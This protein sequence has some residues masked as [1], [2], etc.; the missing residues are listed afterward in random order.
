MKDDPKSRLDATTWYVALLGPLEPRPL[1]QWLTRM[2]LFAVLV[3]LSPTTARAQVPAEEV[4]DPAGLFK[5][6]RLLYL[7]DQCEAAL[8]KLKKVVEQTASP[9]AR[10][11]LGRCLVKEGRLA[12]AYHQLQRTMTDSE[13]SPAKYELTLESAALELGILSAKIARLSIAI[14]GRHEQTRVQLDGK[15]LLAADLSSAIVVVP[16]KHE[17]LVT[18]LGQV[19]RQSVTLFKG[20]AKVVSFSVVQQSQAPAPA[21]APPSLPEDALQQDSGSTLRLAGYIVGG[22]GVAALA[23]GGA[24]GLVSRARF[25]ELNDKCGGQPCTD[26]NDLTQIEDGER[27]DSL[28]TV[29]LVGGGVLLGAGIVA[30]LLGQPGDTPPIS[31]TALVEGGAYVSWQASF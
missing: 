5:E 19:Q 27:L 31:A 7:K 20:E 8:P 11:F 28:A 17:V 29:G 26:P 4:Q 1:L 18:H 14:E 13:K 9:N 15:P 6:G 23:A 16:G 22:I 2:A 25:N 12:E 24:A 30:V 10:L 3:Y 21:S